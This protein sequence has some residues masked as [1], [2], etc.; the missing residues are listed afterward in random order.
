MTVADRARKATE[1]LE[2][3]ETARWVE[4]LESDWLLP[5]LLL[6][7][8]SKQRSLTHIASTA[9]D[10]SI[11]PLALSSHSLGLPSAVPISRQLSHPTLLATA[12]AAQFTQLTTNSGE[13]QLLT[14]SLTRSLATGSTAL[15]LD[16]APPLTTARV[17]SLLPP[18]TLS[19]FSL[20]AAVRCPTRPPLRAVSVLA[21]SLLCPARSVR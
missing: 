5:L 14:H 21:L 6:R 20:C 15:L 19:F 13:L 4:R 3:R 9:A 17:L 1:W 2:A 10:R 16:I 11:N 12:C 7:S 8:G 18:L